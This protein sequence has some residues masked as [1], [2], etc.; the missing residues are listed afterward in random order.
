MAHPDDYSYY[1]KHG[2][3]DV[4]HYQL[5]RSTIQGTQEYIDAVLAKLGLTRTPRPAD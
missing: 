2:C 3:Q 5:G 4:S 1:L